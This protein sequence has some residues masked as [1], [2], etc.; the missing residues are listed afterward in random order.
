MS[1]TTDWADALTVEDLCK[2]M[3]RKGH[4]VRPDTLWTVA[5][6]TVPCWVR[7]VTVASL[8]DALR[9]IAKWGDNANHGGDA[10]Q[11]RVEER[12]RTLL[13]KAGLITYNRAARGWGVI[14]RE[15][16]T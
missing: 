7:E 2:L 4:S 16:P 5:Q 3:S 6:Y 15:V 12:Q 14:P 11:A 13:R 1:T 8:L 10:S 9:A